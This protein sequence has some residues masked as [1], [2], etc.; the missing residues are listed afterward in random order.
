MLEDMDGYLITVSLDKKNIVKIRPFS[1]AKTE[2]IQDYLMHDKRDFDPSIFIIHVDTNNLSTN[3]S[4]EMIADKVF[5][6]AESF[7]IRG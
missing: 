1:S 2:N 4:P 6:T 5:E 7:K 3:D